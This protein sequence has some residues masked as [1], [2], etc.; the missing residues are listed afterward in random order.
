M[1]PH[2]STA[3]PLTWASA[4]LI[5]YAT[6]HPWAGW[7]WPVPGLFTWVLPKQS[8]ELPGDLM[9]N[10]VGYMPLGA[11]MC[12]ASLRSGRGALS[13]SL[14]TVLLCS[15]LSYGLELTQFAL[16]GRVPSISDWALNS[17]GAAWGVLA[18]ITAYALGLVDWWHRWRERLLIPQA[19]F[20]LALLWLWPLGLLFP[21]PLP[22]GEGQLGPVLRLLL[23]DWTADTPWQSWFLPDGDPLSLFVSP[24]WPGQLPPREVSIEQLAASWW[25]WQ[26]AL[27][28]ALGLL[29]PMA[30]ACAVARSRAL[31]LIL[32][33]GAVVMAVAATAVSTAMNYGPHHAFTWLGLPT[34]VG[35]LLGALCG[36]LLLDRTRTTA[37]VVGVAVL[38][39]LVWLIHQVPPDPYYAQT[40]ML[41]EQGRFIRFHGLSRWLGLLWPY[42]ALVWLLTRVFARGEGRAPKIAA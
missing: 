16:P 5:A 10:L 36:A 42:A 30:V 27:T 40:L 24:M 37:A 32:L 12:I 38:L 11:V 31:R 6:L 34:L 35:L 19:G 22:L 26:N 4:A 3:W 21:P 33:A 18:A 14:I 2:R 25:P 13:A 7:H 8:Y 1:P 17:L 15:A 23:I 28:V 29:A 9:A 20:G 41:W 39:G